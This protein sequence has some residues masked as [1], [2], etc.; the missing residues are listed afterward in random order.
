M[1]MQSF[2]MWF[3]PIGP[4]SIQGEQDCIRTRS[5]Q[6]PSRISH[7]E[8]TRIGSHEKSLGLACEQCD[9]RQSLAVP[10]KNGCVIVIGQDWSA[11]EKCT[12]VIWLLGSDLQGQHMSCPERWI[13]TLSLSETLG[14]ANS[15][16]VLGTE[17]IC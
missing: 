2:G 15:L 8:D 3:Y 16:T 4:F 9:P 7:A 6:E 1:S 14:V 10:G 17:I 11:Y 12:V 5:R 13:A